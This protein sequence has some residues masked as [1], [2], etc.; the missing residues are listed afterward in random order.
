[1]V[2][3][4]CVTAA[5]ARAQRLAR[6]RRWFREDHAHG[7]LLRRTPFER[8]QEAGA[9]CSLPLVVGVLACLLLTRPQIHFHD[10][11]LDV[12]R[13]LRDLKH[14]ADP[15][16]EVASRFTRGGRAVLCLDE[17]MVTDVADA[18]ILRRL[19]Q[20]LFDFG[21]VLV[22][23][24]NRAPER[25]YEHGLQRPLFLP[26]IALLRERCEVHDIQGTRDYRLLAR[27]LAQPL[28]F[29]GPSAS[30]EL[31]QCLDM[32]AHG[33]TPGPVTLSV[34][35]GRTIHVARSAEKVAYLTFSEACEQPV[36]AA[37][38]AALCDRFHTLLIDGVPVFDAATRAAAHRLVTLVDVAYER[39][40]RLIL[41]A[42]APSPEG[43]FT[44]IVTQADYRV[45]QHTQGEE[46]VVDDVVGFAKERTVSRLIEMSSLHYA[47]EHAARHAPE[48]LP[49][50]PPE[51]SQLV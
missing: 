29:S 23:T 10:F 50:L 38:Y 12:H 14:V 42:H 24:S 48:L 34:A 37:D 4:S 21:L 17:L 3:E 28:Y 9:R 13:N 31:Q 51:E 36:A 8:S 39:R 49:S 11:M 6:R 7:R 18:M 32:F 19:F 44:R 40:V 5:C 20:H 45:A 43:L 47:R 26:F 35:M 15:L 2:G 30:S 1:M 41:A 22:S 16:R 25:L 46:L 33:V 27:R